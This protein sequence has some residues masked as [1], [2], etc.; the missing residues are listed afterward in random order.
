MSILIHLP[1]VT[2]LSKMTLEEAIDKRHSKRQFKPD[3]LTMEEMS[4]LLWAAQ[5]MNAAG[6]RTVPSAGALYPLEIYTV[7]AEGVY[8]YGPKGHELQQ[9]KKNC[10]DRNYLAAGCVGQMWMAN[11]P[12]IIVIAADPDKT[13]AKYGERGH[14]YVCMEAGNVSQNISLQAT[15]LGMGTTIVGAFDDVYVH[16]LLGLMTGMFPLL[17][18]PVGKV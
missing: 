11:A 10:D 18:M 13:L 5:G 3:A 17:I 12:L 6:T 8:R 1:P 4:R 15:A 2:S 9:I 16:K 7:T 14:R